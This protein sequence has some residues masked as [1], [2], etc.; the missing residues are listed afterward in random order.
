MR[1]GR[2]GLIRIRLEL[3]KR[4]HIRL[5]GIELIRLL[6]IRSDCIRWAQIK[7]DQNRLDQH[8][9]LWVCLEF[10][11][12]RA[13]VLGRK[14]ERKIKLEEGE[15]NDVVRSSDERVQDAVDVGRIL[16]WKTRWREDASD[17]LFDVIN[18][19]LAGCKGINKSAR[20]L[21][22]CAPLPQQWTLPDNKTVQH[23]SPGG[24]RSRIGI[25]VVC[26]PFI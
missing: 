5:K 16:R 14:R 8:R 23:S 10:F 7:S 24:G 11:L 9:W 3:T 15:L 6:D 19:A 1:I 13:D 22:P 18:D 17:F 2:I 21:N 25:A 26:R 12:R 20:R 4:I